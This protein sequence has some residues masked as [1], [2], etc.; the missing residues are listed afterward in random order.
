MKLLNST[1]F[2]LLSSNGR[3]NRS[4]FLVGLL[5]VAILESFALLLIKMLIP[6]GAPFYVCVTIS[7]IISVL[8]MFNLIMKRVNDIGG[9]L[10]SALFVASVLFTYEI[11]DLVSRVIDTSGIIYTILFGFIAVIY[12]ILMFIALIKLCFK[13]SVKSTTEQSITG[14][15]K[16]AIFL[17]ISYIM[18]SSAF[19]F[20]QDTAKLEESKEVVKNV[21]IEVKKEVKETPKEPELETVTGNPLTNEDCISYWQNAPKPRGFEKLSTKS[22]NIELDAF[23]TYNCKI[24]DEN[25]KTNIKTSILELVKANDFKTIND[26]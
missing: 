20:S 12:S 17:A 25:T 4:E 6:A 1:K 8:L 13:P 19:D 18:S 14:T 9:G 7:A 21:V 3:I 15:Q 23:I 2:L 11:L 26:F 10:K 24:I 22:Q 5:L 16:A